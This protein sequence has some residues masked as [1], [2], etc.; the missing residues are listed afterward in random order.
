MS[1][2]TTVDDN[3]SLRAL[4]E[5]LEEKKRQL[6]ETILSWATRNPPRYPWRQRGE[7]PCEVFIGEFWLRETSPPVAVRVYHRFV[8]RFLSIMDL[9]EAQ[10]NG[11]MQ[12]VPGFQL[13]ANA[14]H[15][16]LVAERLLEQGKGDLP[17]DSESLARA[18]GLEHHHISA[19]ICFGFG[20]PVA[21]VDSHVGRMLLRVFTSSLPSRAPSGLLRAMA[22]TLVPDIDPQGYNSALLDVAGVICRDEVPLCPE[23][24]VVELCDYARI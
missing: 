5:V 18:S 15:M 4:I 12:I 2:Q 23:C 6:R 13:R 19:A 1:N 24:P 16:R 9:A 14:R 17:K 11:I 3:E 10:E 8:Q 7:T 22:Q 21:V 20:Q